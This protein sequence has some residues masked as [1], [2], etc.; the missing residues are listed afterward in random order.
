LGVV[1]RLNS[2]AKGIINRV[3]KQFEESIE[4]IDRANGILE[5]SIQKCVNKEEELNEKLRENKMTQKDAYESIQQNKKL[6]DK[7]MQFIK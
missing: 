4:E 1:N 6:K 7:F 5:D 2:K 3:V